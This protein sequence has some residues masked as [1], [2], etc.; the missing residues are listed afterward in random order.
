[1]GDETSAPMSKR[2]R[3]AIRKESD[4]GDRPWA[5]FFVNEGDPIDALSLAKV[6]YEYGD[7]GNVTE[8]RRELGAVA[9]R[10]AKE[11]WRD[12]DSAAELNI[13]V[14]IDVTRGHCTERLVFELPKLYRQHVL[15]A[16]PIVGGVGIVVE[17]EGASAAA[18][19]SRP[20]LGDIVQRA[21]D[22]RSDL[23]D[24][25]EEPL[26]NPPPPPEL[27]A[28]CNEVVD[29]LYLLSDDEAVVDHLVVERIVDGLRH[30]GRQSR[31]PPLSRWRRSA[32]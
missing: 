9:S 7:I 25:M 12:D 10:S 22:L 19:E 31:S 26:E 30:Q 23:T 20:S 27:L 6:G 3:L 18:I 17:P 21:S 28:A 14:E 11:I 15:V 16:L 4:G 1:M 5:F 32:R 2:A 8:V 24:F 13:C 29:A